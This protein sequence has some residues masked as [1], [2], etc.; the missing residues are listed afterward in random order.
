MRR[1][2]LGPVLRLRL[3]SCDRLVIVRL[4]GV[5]L[6]DRLFLLLDTLRLGVPVKHQLGLVAVLDNFRRDANL[7]EVVLQVTGVFLNEPLE[8]R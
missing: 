5:D 4:S 3:V 8:D 1:L 6:L 2:F 7:L